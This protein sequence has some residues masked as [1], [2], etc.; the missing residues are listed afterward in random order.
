M[1]MTPKE[2]ELL[3]Y[4]AEEVLIDDDRRADYQRM[5]GD[6]RFTIKQL[7]SQVVADGDRRSALED[8]AECNRMLENHGLS[9][10]GESR[11]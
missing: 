4:I 1:A 10:K 2:R 5:D 7:I 11:R 6:R 3:L 9:T 8:E